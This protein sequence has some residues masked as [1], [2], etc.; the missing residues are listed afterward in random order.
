MLLEKAITILV[1][2]WPQSKALPRLFNSIFNL[3]I[4]PLKKKRLKKIAIKQE[5][6]AVIIQKLERQETKELIEQK[7]LNCGSVVPNEI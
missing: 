7:M 4:F 2:I 6:L 5:K 3:Y 1:T